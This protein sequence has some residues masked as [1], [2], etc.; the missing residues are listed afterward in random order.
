MSERWSEARRSPVAHR[1]SD[2]IDELADK[3]TGEPPPKR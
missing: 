3:L 1:V 2:L